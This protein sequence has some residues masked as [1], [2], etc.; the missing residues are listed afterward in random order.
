MC[1]NNTN[2]SMDDTCILCN[3][4][5]VEIS[6]QCEKMHDFCFSCIEKWT[7]EKECMICPLCNKKCKLFIKMP[8]SNKNISKNFQNFL[9]S[10]DIIPNALK[11]DEKCSCFN[12]YFTNTCVYPEW[13]LVNY[14]ENKKQLYTYY[15][16]MEKYKEDPKN[17]MEVIKWFNVLK[18]VKKKINH[19]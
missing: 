6:M 12:N 4:N 18:N 8:K 16:N 10:L 1:E 2:N 5:K 9:N 17:P 3:D 19:L 7:K 11:H 15:K 14:I 13:S